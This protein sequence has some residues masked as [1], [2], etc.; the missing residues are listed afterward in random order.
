MT[1]A[2]QYQYRI[3]LQRLDAEGE[4]S[5]V[6]DML[7]TGH[8][9]EASICAIVGQIIADNEGAPTPEDLTNSEDS[10]RAGLAWM[11]L[12]E[13]RGTVKALAVELRRM[14]AGVDSA[15]AASSG[16]RYDVALAADMYADRLVS[17]AAR[18]VSA[19]KA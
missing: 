9:A 5:E 4:P 7:E 17:A 10:L 13:V 2:T 6:L 14:A 3:T 18:I 15:T 8:A 16:S 11:R 19:L 12:T 1:D